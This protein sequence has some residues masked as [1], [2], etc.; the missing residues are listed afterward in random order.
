MTRALVMTLVFMTCYHIAM[1]LLVFEKVY[2]LPRK[3]LS[4]VLLF[5]SN[6]FI[7]TTFKLENISLYKVIDGSEE[8]W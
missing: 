8:I 7:C 3:M 5:I 2:S 4:H 1:V 6:V